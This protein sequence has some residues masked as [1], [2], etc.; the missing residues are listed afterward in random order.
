MFDRGLVI[1][2]THISLLKG[3]WLSS[4]L[5]SWFN[6]VH[7]SCILALMVDFLSLRI[8]ISEV[9]STPPSWTSTTPTTIYLVIAVVEAQ[10]LHL[11]PFFRYLFSSVKLV[12]T[13]MIKYK[14]NLT[15]L[16]KSVS[17]Y[18]ADIPTLPKV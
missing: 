1:G 14:S 2:F 6:A 4:Y 12:S 11:C 10:N 7:Q 8:E 18:F 16:W 9:H 3:I 17:Q 13:Q 5:F 15:F